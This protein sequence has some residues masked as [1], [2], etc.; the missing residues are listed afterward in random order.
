MNGSLLF[1]ISVLHWIFLGCFTFSTHLLYTFLAGRCVEIHEDTF[2][3]ESRKSLCR[4]DLSQVYG[5]IR[6][7][8]KRPLSNDTKF[9]NLFSFGFLSKIFTHYNI[10][11]S[12]CKVFGNIS[13]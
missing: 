8:E 2:L 13:Q 11:F 1:A 4:K 7:Y 3:P 6:S 12:L 5:F 9:H 10:F